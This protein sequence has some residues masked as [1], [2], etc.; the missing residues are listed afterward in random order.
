LVHLQ[1]KQ[2]VSDI[3][4]QS[5]GATGSPSFTTRD[6]ETTAVVQ[7]GET[8][9]IGGII[10][11][12]KNRDRIGI[13]FLMDIPVLGHFFGSTTEAVDRTE[14]VMLITPHVIRNLEE[15]R[16][17]TRDFQ[18]RLSIVAQEIER[19]RREEAER[20]RPARR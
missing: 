1:V 10:S 6:A 2:E 4:V 18:E 17:V 9:V 19:M 7:D 16:R 12:R 11:E 15:A 14:L 5:F 20:D 13:P 3:G 8:L